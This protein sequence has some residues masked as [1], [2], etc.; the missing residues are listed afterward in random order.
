MKKKILIIVSHPDDEILGC[1]GAIN[2]HL[3]KKDDIFIYFT[4]ECSSFRFD[5]KKDKRISIEN[6]KREDKAKK[7]AKDFNYKILGFGNNINLDTININHLKNVKKIIELINKIKPDIMYTHYDKDLNPDHFFA[8]KFVITACRPTNFLVKKIYLMEVPSSTDWNISD[9]FK[10]NFFLKIDLKVKQKM[11]NY[12]KSE[13]KNKPHP[14]SF[15]NIEA[16]SRFR[17]GQAG[18]EYA[19]AFMVYREIDNS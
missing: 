9:T 1:G 19:E 4:H 2:H 14:T 5:N 7:L 15:K 10:P 11:M 6:K 3:K 12:Y 18:I 13:M 8:N 17:G 16:L